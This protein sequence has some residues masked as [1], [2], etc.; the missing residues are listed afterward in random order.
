MEVLAKVQSFAEEHAVTIGACLLVVVLLAGVAWFTLTRNT[1]KSEVL[2]N[3]A[4][5]NEAST[6]QPA[7]LPTQEQ[8]EEMARYREQMESKNAADSTVQPQSTE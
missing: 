2:E 1:T 3:A 5:V 4:R 7:P 6:S 8:I